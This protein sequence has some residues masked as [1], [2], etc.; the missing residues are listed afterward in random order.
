LADAL[1]ASPSWWLVYWDDVSQLYL[2]KVPAH[3]AVIA[4]FGSK[5]VNPDRQLLDQYQATPRGVV[6]RAREI[7][8]RNAE[9]APRSYRARIMAGNACLALGDL[10][11]AAAHY[12]VALGVLDPPNAWIHYQIARC[13]LGLED[14]PAAELHL[15]ACLA[16]APEFA[17]GRRALAEVQLRRGPPG[18]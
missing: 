5:L 10:A 7:A 15:R 1:L 4:R 14:L 3:A 12:E 17:E 18:P 16:L 13:R 2:E 9:L 8:E 6:A 11:T